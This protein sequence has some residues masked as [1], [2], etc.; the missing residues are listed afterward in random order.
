MGVNEREPSRREEEEGESNRLK[1]LPPSLL[2]IVSCKR[3]AS[4]RGVYEKFSGFGARSMSEKAERR[5]RDER[6][7]VSA[8]EE[9]NSVEKESVMRKTGVK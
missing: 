2:Y 7:D 4:K 9:E 6:F 5:E 8:A 3:G 1:N